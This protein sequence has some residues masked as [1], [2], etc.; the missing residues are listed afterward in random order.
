MGQDFLFYKESQNGTSRAQ[1]GHRGAESNK[2]Q[3]L[4][5]N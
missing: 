4:F 2:Q 5:S 1:K 3:K